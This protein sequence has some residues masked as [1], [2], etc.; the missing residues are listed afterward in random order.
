MENNSIESQ[1]NETESEQGWQNINTVTY[2]VA[3][4]STIW[5]IG[6]NLLILVCFFRNRQRQWTTFSRQT[7]SM[8]VSDLMVGLTAIPFLIVEHHGGR[9]QWFVCY[10]TFY[11]FFSAQ[12]VTL[13]HVLG[14][15]LL[16][17]IKMKEFS[18]P[19]PESQT[20]CYGNGLVTAAWT[21][22]FVVI[23]IP[24]LMWSK[25]LGGT[26]RI[27]YCAV[28]KLFGNDHN[29]A[30]VYLAF[31]YFVSQCFTN[32]MYITACTRFW[33]ELHKIVPVQN[34]SSVQNLSSSISPG[35][36]SSQKHMGNNRL[37]G[38]VPDPIL[39]A[40]QAAQLL[41][42]HK[43]GLLQKQVKFSTRRI[44]VA[45][46]EMQE[47][48][49]THE[50]ASTDLSHKSTATG[51]IQKQITVCTVTKHVQVTSSKRLTRSPLDGHQN[52]SRTH[53]YPRVYKPDNVHGGRSRSGASNSGSTSKAT[54]P[55]SPILKS[56]KRVTGT[57][58]ILLLLFNL[59]TLPVTVGIFMENTKP[60]DRNLRFFV[61]TLFLVN[62]GLNPIVYATRVT[63]LRR[64]VVKIF[65]EVAN[66]FCF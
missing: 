63:S 5:T 30:F 12:C 61:S 51:V 43:V 6:A 54:Q 58:G 47:K 7:C 26:E 44:E 24:I 9:T 65:R 41:N 13:Y 57:I 34:V 59:F 39:P 3:V 28:D 10:F 42:T 38:E 15:C 21:M 31:S 40:P 1:M 60:G 45:P 2:A 33:I 18:N 27:M 55:L 48:N 8:S 23:L 46:S 20:C 62:S 29:K 37:Q 56:Q 22:P 53:E 32:I 11:M 35:V 16:R 49:E 64:A 17:L 66:I 14:V 50:N 25:N 4:I 52:T 36:G 19:L